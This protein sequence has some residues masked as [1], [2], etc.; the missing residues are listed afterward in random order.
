VIGNELVNL[1][2]LY[3]DDVRICL[4][5]LE[6]EAQTHTVALRLAMS[7]EDDKSWPPHFRI[8]KSRLRLRLVDNVASTHTEVRSKSSQERRRGR[9]RRR[10]RRRLNKMTGFFP[11]SNHGKTELD[12]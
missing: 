9:R 6:E 11:P 8:W 5:V 7:D 4:G 10:R 3:D 2:V 12:M 1:S